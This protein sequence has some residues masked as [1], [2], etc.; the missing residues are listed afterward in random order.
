MRFDFIIVASLLW[1]SS[2]QNLALPHDFLNMGNSR[3]AIQLTVKKASDGW[4][5]PSDY[6]L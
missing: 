1:I 3:F 6:L 4:G 5:L 2:L